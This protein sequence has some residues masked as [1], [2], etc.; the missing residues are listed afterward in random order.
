MKKRNLA[1]LGLLVLASPL[2]A[3]WTEGGARIGANLDTLVVTFQGMGTLFR[4]ETFGDAAD[5]YLVDTTGTSR[6]AVWGDGIGGGG[7]INLYN[8]SGGPT[9]S[10]YGGLSGDNA[11]VFPLDAIHA[12]EIANEAGVAS[13]SDGVNSVA[14]SGTGRDTLLAQSIVAPDSGYLLIIGS[15]QVVIYH[16][17]G[18]LSAA[19][20]GIML[21]STVPSNQD[22]GLSLPS[23]APTGFYR[24]P[25]TAQILQPVGPGSHD[26]VFWG[27]EFSGDYT[28]LDM[29]LSV[30][31]LPTAYGTVAKVSSRNVPD[32]QAP[33][34]TVTPSLH[35]IRAESEAANRAR[36]E[37]ELAKI[38][39]QLEA[40][41]REMRKR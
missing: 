27:E 13:S 14:L 5:L 20:L 12:V 6:F 2:S 16:A 38:R 34:R 18:T 19:D 7:Q 24:L 40:L 41:E 28:V 21:D 32:D 15:A 36:I 10:L 30:V 35:T 37:A 22:L 26:V 31:Y 3:Q 23:S 4:L 11:V 33:R 39:A 9:M 8:A 17:N 1:V 25:I 29:Q